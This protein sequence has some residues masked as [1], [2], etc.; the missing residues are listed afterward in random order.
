M[1]CL[2][3]CRRLRE[4]VLEPPRQAALGHRDGLAHLLRKKAAGTNG[5]AFI[6]DRTG[7]MIASSAPDGDA[8]AQSAIAALARHARPPTAPAESVFQ[9]DHVTAKP[10]ARQAAA[11]EQLGYQGRGRYLAQCPDVTLTRPT[12][13]GMLLGA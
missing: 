11:P 3:P 10:L 7:G 13:L 6:L 4:S 12:F 5:R 1:E 8:V 9:F 2:L